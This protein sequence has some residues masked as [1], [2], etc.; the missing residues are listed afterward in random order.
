MIIK[1]KHILFDVLKLYQTHS[2]S[3]IQIS[4]YINSFKSSCGNMHKINRIRSFAIAE[5]IRHFHDQVN[6]LYCSRI[7]FQD[8]FSMN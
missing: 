8:L 6:K 3:L 1:N 4:N 7:N 2:M 5:L